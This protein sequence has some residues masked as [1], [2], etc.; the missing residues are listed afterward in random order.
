VLQTS[1]WKKVADIK[2]ERNPTGFQVLLESISTG[3][4]VSSPPRV[5]HRL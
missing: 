3:Q 4:E 1:V 5:R 2:D